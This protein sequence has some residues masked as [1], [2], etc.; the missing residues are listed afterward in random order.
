MLWYKARKGG[1]KVNSHLRQLCEKALETMNPDELSDLDS[2][3]TRLLDAKLKN[4][5]LLKR[6][7]TPHPD[8]PD[9][10]GKFNHVPPDKNVE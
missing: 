2:E 8:R 9:P 5:N 10:P 1:N 3:I 7:S 4:L 6:L